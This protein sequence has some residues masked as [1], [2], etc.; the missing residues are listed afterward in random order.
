MSFCWILRR[1]SAARRASSSAEIFLTFLG[2]PGLGAL[3]L[4]RRLAGFLPFLLFAPFLESAPFL[5]GGG[6]FLIKKGLL[7]I[8]RAKR[9]LMVL[10]STALSGPVTWHQ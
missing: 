9:V 5:L 6:F 2:G 8:N 1:R 3:G 7:T 4:G 10:M